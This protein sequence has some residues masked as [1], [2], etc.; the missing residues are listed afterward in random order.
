[1]L[2]TVFSAV[3]MVFL[4]VKGNLKLLD[5]KIALKIAVGEIL[6]FVKRQITITNFGKV[7]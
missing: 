1:M 2:R 7:S 4:V 3:F 6:A 5:L